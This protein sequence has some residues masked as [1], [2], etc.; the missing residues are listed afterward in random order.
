VK[1]GIPR[2][3][4]VKNRHPDIGLW[5]RRRKREQRMQRQRARGQR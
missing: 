2:V 5:I 1:G 3:F 4:R